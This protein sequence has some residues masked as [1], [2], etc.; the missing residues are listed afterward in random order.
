MSQ[1][2]PWRQLEGRTGL[3]KIERAA[4]AETMRQIGHESAPRVRVGGTEMSG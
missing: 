1:L 3:I 2:P 4:W